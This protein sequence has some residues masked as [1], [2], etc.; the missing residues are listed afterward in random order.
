MRWVEV[1]GVSLR[2]R[3]TGQGRSTIVLL[4]EIGGTLESYDDVSD[5]LSGD[6][7]VLRYDMRGAGLSE[8]PRIRLVLQDLVED[9]AAL[10]DNQ[11][12]EAAVIAGCAIG[13]T[14]ALAFAAQYPGRTYSVLAMAPAAGLDAERKPLA[15]L[16]AQEIEQTGQRHTIDSRLNK[17]YP[18]ELRTDARRFEQLRLR[19]L[20]AD[21]F[22]TGAMLRMLAELD[23]RPVLSQVNVPVLVVAGEMDGDRP[24]E[25][26]KQTADSL[27]TARFATLPSGH[28]M[29]VHAPEKVAAFIRS[30]AA[31]KGS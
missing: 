19:R 6:F 7:D 21:P 13:A 8:K 25:N 22:G 1:N 9:L 3:R 5:L 23:F 30:E 18:P 11:G 29:H 16:R 27:K 26:V 15:I 2:Y 14:V 31:A 20:G 4:H 24:V 12:I 28:F 17:S 10:M